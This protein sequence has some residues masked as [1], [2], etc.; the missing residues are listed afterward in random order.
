MEEYMRVACI[1]NI[2]FDHVLICDTFPKIGTRT[3]FKN[4][5]MTPGGPAS[6]AAAV[7]RKFGVPTDMYGQIG[8]DDLKNSI[9]SCFEK[10]RIGTHHIQVSEN[11][12]T[13]IGYVIDAKGDQMRTILGYK[14]EKDLAIPYSV[15]DKS[16]E[17]D[18]GYDVILTDGKYP[19][20]TCELIARNQDA[21][22]IIDAGRTKTGVME[23]CE[24]GAIDYIVCSEE[25]ANEASGAK[26]DFDNPQTLIEVY[27][28][29]VRRFPGSKIVIT[30]GKYGCLYENNGIYK[31]VEPYVKPEKASTLGAGD[32]F[33]GAFAFGIAIG[34]NLDETIILASATS[35]LSTT[36]DGGRSSIPTLDE[37]ETLLKSEESLKLNNITEFS[38]QQIN[39]YILKR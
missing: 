20:E 27:D 4:V 3:D 29:L 21:I 11:Y 18:K 8:D 6:N 13:P 5:I 36:K 24:S 12:K 34:L 19:V 39:K 31:N 32:I 16:P 9:I 33:H 30:L 10:E 26:I 23:L 37:V 2:T 15:M 1:G 14:H 28:K 17:Y 38:K 25:F 22:T 35:S 7:V